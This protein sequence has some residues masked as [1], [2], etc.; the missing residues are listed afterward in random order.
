MQMCFE[1]FRRRECEPLVEG[2]VGLVV[3]LEHFEETHRDVA[4]ILDVVAHR[5]GHIAD[6]VFSKS[7]VRAWPEAAN[8][9]MRARP[10][11]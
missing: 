11:V 3:A 1:Q 10:S 4:G 7:K 6:V 8:T 2:H 5:E 9:P